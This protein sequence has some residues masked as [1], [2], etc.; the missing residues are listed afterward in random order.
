MAIEN[1]LPEDWDALLPEFE[2][3]E[4]N[5]ATRKASSEMINAIA[6]KYRIFLAEVLIW[7]A[8]IT[9]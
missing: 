4:V 1:K 7:P 8:L 3:G 6:K 5:Q 9:Q 2:A